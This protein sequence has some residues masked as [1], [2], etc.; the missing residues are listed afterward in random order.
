MPAHSRPFAP[1]SLL[2]TLALSF[3]LTG[4]FSAPLF[5]QQ[6]LE[7]WRAD[8]F[9]TFGEW[10]FACE[11]HV[12]TEESRCYLQ[13]AQPYAPRPSFRSGVLW[14]VKN[15]PF[16]YVSL[17]VEQGARVADTA[18]SVTAGAERRAVEI[19]LERCAAEICDLPVPIS[20]A[21]IDAMLA[22]DGEIVW[23]MRP[24]SVE[25]GGA[26]NRPSLSFDLDAFREAYAVFSEAA[27]G[28]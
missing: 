6:Q 4:V 27:P 7:G 5:A 8:R 9:E 24:L 11:T 28:G 16:E 13:A 1:A 21:L 23:T 20:R 17:G 18:L 15:G 19:P 25:D 26:E 14:V 10:V 3:V 12:R 22:E 2:S